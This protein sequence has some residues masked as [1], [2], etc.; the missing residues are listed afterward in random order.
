M[1]GLVFATMLGLINYLH[2]KPTSILDIVPVDY[3]SNL[4]LCSTV[5]AAQ[6][7]KDLNIVHSSTSSQNPAFIVDLIRMCLHEFKT[8]PS[9]KQV[10][11]PH[12]TP[13]TNE[14]VYEALFFIQSELPLQ[15]LEKL[16]MMPYIGSAKKRE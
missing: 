11:P 8:H 7:T 10:F 1:G 5:H 2:C 14:R 12:L 3:V 13:I 6:D 4:I 9:Q 16:S 15:I